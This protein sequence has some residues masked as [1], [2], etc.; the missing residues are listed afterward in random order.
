[1]G[2][3]EEDVQAGDKAI[4][5]F[6]N[7]FWKK[8]K[9]LSKQNCR[10]YSTSAPGLIFSRFVDCRFDDRTQ[11]VVSSS[12]VGSPAPL[13]SLLRALIPVNPH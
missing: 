9:K 11:K 6:V 5:M 3:R 13:T 7:H 12:D 1:M 8:D 10:P 4:I 2:V